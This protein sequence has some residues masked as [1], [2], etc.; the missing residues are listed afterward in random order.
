MPL[1]LHP[2]LRT[3]EEHRELSSVIQPL[4]SQGVSVRKADEAAGK[5]P[6]VVPKL[7]IRAHNQETITG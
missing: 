6:K 2:H 3:L 4:D 5:F 1:H 7:V